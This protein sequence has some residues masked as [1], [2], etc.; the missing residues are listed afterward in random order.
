[1]NCR[2]RQSATT[3][4]MTVRWLNGKAKHRRQLR[5]INC[6]ELTRV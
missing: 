4:E 1:M 3:S 5:G 6:C 2:R